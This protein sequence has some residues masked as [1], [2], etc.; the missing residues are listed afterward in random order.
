MAIVRGSFFPFPIAYYKSGNYY[1]NGQ[2][3][4]ESKKTD[5]VLYIIE[6]EDIFNHFSRLFLKVSIIYK[7]T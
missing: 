2:N 6:I 7:R 4:D 3:N 5:I 1:D